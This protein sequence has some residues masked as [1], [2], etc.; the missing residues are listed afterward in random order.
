MSVPSLCSL[1]YPNPLF[2]LPYFFAISN[3]LFGCAMRWRNAMLLAGFE[4]LETLTRFKGM[5]NSGNVATTGAIASELEKTLGVL[6]TFEDILEAGDRYECLFKIVCV[7]VFFCF[8]L[9]GWG[10]PPIQEG[11]TTPSMSSR[12]RT[13]LLDVC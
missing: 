1:H 9:G 12:G 10:L 11:R 3:L 13:L 4:H 7:C 8:F 2:F 6:A 5:V